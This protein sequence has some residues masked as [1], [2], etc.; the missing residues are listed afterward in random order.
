M[1][2]SDSNI[3]I[4]EHYE[5]LGFTDHIKAALRTIAPG[6]QLM[7]VAQLAPLDQFHTRGRHSRHG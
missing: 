1:T 5:A 3:K 6:S 2:A 7:T 4:R